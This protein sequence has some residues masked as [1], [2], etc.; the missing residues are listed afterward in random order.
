MYV[1]RDHSAVG[2]VALS[3]GKQFIHGAMCVCFSPGLLVERCWS[4]LRTQ[5]I[6][7]NINL[8]IY[9]F[10]SLQFSTLRFCREIDNKHNSC[11]RSALC[12][13][14]W[15][16]KRAQIKDFENV[17]RDRYRNSTKKVFPFLIDFVVGKFYRKQE[18]WTSARRQAI[19]CNREFEWIRG[20][21]FFRLISS[22]SQTFSKPLR[23]IS[24]KWTGDYT[25]WQTAKHSVW[26]TV[27]KVQI[28]IHE[29]SK[30]KNKISDAF[31]WRN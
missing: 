21:F 29:R 6:H 2:G 11:I 18:T 26:K 27:S 15:F 5:I 20:F 9:F 1:K 13:R 30:R 25:P 14:L 10:L 17:D 31:H 3:V 19:D 16:L 23:W 12:A 4:L 28:H 7:N 8:F 22:A 24:E